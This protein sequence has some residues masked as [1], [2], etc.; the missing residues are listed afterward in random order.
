MSWSRFRRGHVDPE[1]AE[2]SRQTLDAASLGIRQ[3]ARHAHDDCRLLRDP[4]VLE[5][6]ADLRADRARLG[7]EFPVLLD[8]RLN[9]QADCTFLKCFTHK[10]VVD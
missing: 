1:S 5:Q 7:E 8:N 9:L 10:L 3:L 6:V 2:P 4:A